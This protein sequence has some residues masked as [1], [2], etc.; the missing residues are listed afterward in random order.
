M[1]GT[2]KDPAT[3]LTL[4]AGWN[5]VGYLPLY[6]LD[7]AAA[8]ASIRWPIPAVSGD[9]GVF[10]VNLPPDFNTLEQSQAGDGYLIYMSEAG[11]LVYPGASAA[12]QGVRRS[13]PAHL[14]SCPALPG[15][16]F[17]TE[18]WGYAN[19]SLPAGAV[20]T[21]LNPRGDIVGC[22][23]VQAAGQFGAMRVYGEDAGA[24]GPIPGHAQ[25]REH[26]PAGGWRTCLPGRAPAL[27]ERPHA[28]R[29]ER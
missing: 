7:V 27:A 11:T 18:V 5:W 21:A 12:G 8:L 20:V 2:P 23:T 26:R 22:Y 14:A 25:R 4:H 24:A 28:A 3:P 17:Y 13:V 10:D 15:T 29:G 19:G 16:P 6:P 1:L 9:A